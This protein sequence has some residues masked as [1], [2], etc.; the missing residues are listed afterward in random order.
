MDC[1]GRIFPLLAKEGWPRRQKNSPVPKRRGRGGH[2]QVKF[3]NAF[4]T[5]RVIDHSVCG[6]A[7]ASRLFID[8]AATPPWQG[9]E[10]DQT[11]RFPDP[12]RRSYQRRRG[13]SMRV[14][15]V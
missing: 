1:S 4:E 3:G 9:G 7:V 10:S 13:V 11:E 6:A 5:C 2:S 8:A 12:F 14:L 15:T